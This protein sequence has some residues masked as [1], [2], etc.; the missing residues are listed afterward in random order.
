MREARLAMPRA[1]AVGVEDAGDCALVLEAGLN[2]HRCRVDIDMQRPMLPLA[3]D[4]PRHD[5]QVVGRL[6]PVVQGRLQPE[7]SEPSTVV[8]PR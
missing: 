1:L 6:V 3:V 5:V 8:R 7:S 2:P 4:Q